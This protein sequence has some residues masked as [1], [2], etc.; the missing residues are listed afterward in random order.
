MCSEKYNPISEHLTLKRNPL[1]KP[2]MLMAHHLS[3]HFEPRNSPFCVARSL[4]RL[5][6]KPR[7]STPAPPPSP[8]SFLRPGTMRPHPSSRLCASSRRSV[9]SAPA[10]RSR[11]SDDQ[12]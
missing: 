10:R 1:S 3:D 4:N 6:L 2:L 9:S 12:L 11:Q 5:A 7:F 8:P